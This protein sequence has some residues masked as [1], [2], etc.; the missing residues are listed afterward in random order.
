[1]LCN[2]RKEKIIKKYPIS[3]LKKSFMLKTSLNDEIIDK[4]TTKDKDIKIGLYVLK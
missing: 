2:L 3:N 4:I 1:M